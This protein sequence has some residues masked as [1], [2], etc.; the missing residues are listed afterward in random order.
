MQFSHPLRGLMTKPR[1]VL[2]SS[3][4]GDIFRRLKFSI[5]LIFTQSTAKKRKTRRNENLHR[6]SNP[7]MSVSHPCP[8]LSCLR[9]LS[10][11]SE[12]HQ[13]HHLRRHDRV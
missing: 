10:D 13:Q 12:E 1:C 8:V 11:A 5:W 7:A 4:P 9:M 2:N 3:R 6:I